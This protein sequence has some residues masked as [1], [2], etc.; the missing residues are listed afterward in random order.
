MEPEPDKL[1]TI[2]GQVRWAAFPGGYGDT[3]ELD[4]PREYT[5]YRGARFDYG[6]T[7]AQ[8]SGFTEYVEV[9]RQHDPPLAAVM[10]A[11]R[12]RNEAERESR[13]A[14]LRELRDRHTR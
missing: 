9:D 7:L 3:H 13:N 4:P 6:W 14:Y 2:D 8:E 5:G 12:D 11:T 10:L 1:P